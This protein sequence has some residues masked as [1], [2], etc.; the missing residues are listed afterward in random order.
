M[1]FNQCRI[2]KPSKNALHAI[3][4]AHIMAL[5]MNMIKDGVLPNEQTVD[6]R[7]SILKPLLPMFLAHAFKRI[8]EEKILVK[9]VWEKAGI[10]QCFNADFQRHG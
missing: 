7:I 6:L 9:N 8:S 1:P 10:L 4:A 2:Q 3:F 5:H